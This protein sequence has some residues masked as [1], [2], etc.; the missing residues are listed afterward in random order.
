[1]S[2]SRAAQP[3]TPLTSTPGKAPCTAVSGILC[4]KWAHFAYSVAPHE[5]IYGVTCW[6]RACAVQWGCWINFHPGLAWG[7]SRSTFFV[8]GLTTAAKPPSST[9]SNRLMWVYWW[10]FAWGFSDS[11][12][13]A[14]F[15][16]SNLLGPFSQEWKHVSQ[17][18]A[19]IFACALSFLTLSSSLVFFLLLAQ[20]QTQEIVPTIGFNVEKF[21]SSR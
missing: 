21:K 12:L 3:V 4:E 17:V 14:C 20:T 6:C 15:Q 7:R 19:M 10:I 16:H 13:A 2:Q 1:M 8:W 11:L 5:P 9:N 18:K